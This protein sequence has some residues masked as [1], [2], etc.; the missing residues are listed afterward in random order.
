MALNTIVTA[1][2]IIG[3]TVTEEQLDVA[4]SLIDSYTDYRW[5]Q[6]TITETKSGDSV[7]HW[8]EL[9]API[10]SVTSFTIDDTS[11]TETTDYEI[12]SIEGLIRTFHGLSWGHDNIVITYVYG[13]VSTDQFFK[14]TYNSVKYAEAALALMLK[15]NPLLLLNIGIE[16]VA[17]GFTDMDIRKILAFVPKST[18]FTALGPSTLYEP[19]GNELI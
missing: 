2:A 1:K 3:Q 15:K 18:F 12:R 5:E 10:I 8:L 13:W 9:R 19:Q 14:D 4:K 6:T 11:Q 7:S 17:L 16:G